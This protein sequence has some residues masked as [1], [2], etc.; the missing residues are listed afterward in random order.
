M[1][2]QMLALDNLYNLDAPDARP[3]RASDPADPVDRA[4]FD[5]GWDHARHGLVP[6]PGWLLDANPVSQGWRAGRA[7]FGARTLAATQPVRHWLELRARAWREGV[8]FET[9]HLTAHGLA[10]LRRERCPVL[11]VRLGGAATDPAAPSFQRLNPAAGYA[12]GNVAQTSRAAARAWDGVDI[13]EAV[14]RARRAE[15]AGEPFEG[16]HAAAWWR[17]AALRSFA[18]PLPFH[19]AARLPLAVLPPNRVRLLNAVQ[20]L[21]AL[22]TLQFTLPGWGERLRRVTDMLP[23][24]TLRHDFN[25]WVGALVPRVL[26]AAREADDLRTTLEDAWLGERVG[27]RWQH[28]VLSLGQAG[29]EALLTRVAALPLPGRVTLLLGAEQAVDGWALA[30]AGGVSAAPQVS[31]ATAAKPAVRRRTGR[32]PSPPAPRATAAPR[33]AAR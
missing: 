9:Q 1:N 29:V 24:H 10:Q 8:S 2:Q 13:A 25:L 27:R 21:Q 18:T 7:V 19:E 14:R 23:E 28:F 12:A 33:P 30:D 26:Q 16:L 20:G 5:L 31:A 15:S 32:P 3:S 6:P 11:R 17:L 22:L 4:G